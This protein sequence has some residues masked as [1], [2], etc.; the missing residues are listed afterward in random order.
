MMLIASVD[1]I[2]VV[3]EEEEKRFLELGANQVQTVSVGRCQ[4][5]MEIHSSVGFPLFP[6][7]SEV[8]LRKTDSEIEKKKSSQSK[9]QGHVAAV[10]ASKAFSAVWPFDRFPTPSQ[11]LFLAFD[12]GRRR[13]ETVK[14]A[15]KTKSDPFF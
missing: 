13:L 6:K 7:L 10:A 12:G 4:R 2:V 3:G 14:D 9:S 11:S 15:Q 5:T 1:V 8:S